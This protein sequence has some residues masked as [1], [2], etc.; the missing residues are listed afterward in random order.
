MIVTIILVVTIALFASDRFRLD[1][2]ALV[3]LLALTLT[4]MVSVPEAL[5]GFA[6]PLVLMIAGLFVVGGAVFRTGLADAAGRRM[7]PLATRGRPTLILVLMVVT[8]LLSAFISSTGTVAVMLPVVVGLARRARLAPSQLLIP[9]AFASLLGGMLTLIGTPPNLVV[10]DA[11]RSATGEGFAFFSFGPPGVV[12]L[13]IGIG[14]LTVFGGVLLPNRSGPR[15]VD[16]DDEDALPQAELWRA[17]GLHRQLYSLRVIDS[18]ELEGRT[19]GDAMLRRRYG[20]TV[21]TI[22]SDTDAGRTTR[23][24]S[25][26]VLVRSGDVLTVVGSSTDVERMARYEDLVLGI[27]RPPGPELLLAEVVLPPR[28]SLE[29][30]HPR[31]AHV[32]ERLGLTVL[33]ARRAGELLP[34]DEAHPLMAGDMLLVTGAPRELADLRGDKSEVVLV[35]EPAEL[36]ARRFRLDRAPHALAVLGVMTLLLAFGVVAPVVAVGLAMVAVVMLGCLTMDEAYRSISWESVVLV[37]AVLPMAT[38]L[39]NSGAATT[40]VTTLVDSLGAVGPRVVMIA[41]FLITA[42]LSQVISNT[43]TAVLIAPIAIRVATDLGVAPEPLLMAVAIAAST[44]FLT[45]VASPVNA[46]VLTPGG[47][48]FTDFARVGAPMLVLVLLA[49]WLVVPVFFPF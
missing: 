40:I 41:L 29:G 17:Y 39:E 43:A 21:L 11:L 14:V 48:R 35:T 28:S 24:A 13:V 12:M 26:E 5:A 6:S 38:A 34:A 45:P 42:V 3:S 33:G 46:L 2:V 16:D 22:E 47:Y 7:L 49:T 4:R 32:R 9:L 20:V 27:D 18:S 31:S 30:Q 10:S 8:A 25:P 37:A 15:S 1:L 19:I 36:R 44:A 23:R